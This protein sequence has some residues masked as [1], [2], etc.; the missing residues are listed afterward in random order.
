MCC[1]SRVI[2]ATCGHSSFCP[3]P[4]VEC[5]HASF[6]PSVPWSTGCEI[7][8]HPYKSLRLDQLCPPCQKRRDAL[9]R[10]IEEQQVVKFDEW[11]W[12][13]SYGMP[14]HGGKDYWG[15][16]AEEREAEERKKTEPAADSK[17]KKNGDL[18][19]TISSIVE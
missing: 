14:S 15:K 4:L 3:R 5:R 11:Q 1:H 13:V 18:T 2:F 12:K 17:Q 9:I 7:V 10:D 19:P 6:D 8:A 16:K